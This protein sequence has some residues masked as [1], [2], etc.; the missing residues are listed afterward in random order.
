[1]VI[2]SHN[3][4]LTIPQ[5]FCQL[6]QYLACNV[7][8]KTFLSGVIGSMNR[9]RTHICVFRSPCTRVYSRTGSRIWKRA[10]FIFWHFHVRFVEFYHDSMITEYL[11]CRT[12]FSAALS[13]LIWLC[14]ER[15]EK[16]NF[17]SKPCFEPNPPCS[18]LF[19]FKYLDCKSVAITCY[20]LLY[21]AG[22]ELVKKNVPQF[23]NASRAC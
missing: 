19:A 23:Y 6:W 20:I 21:Q 12:D 14:S 4:M 15:I 3:G 7:E 8:I 22:F 5:R 11:Q 18:Q 2:T 9:Q 10:I 17:N 13:I 16:N 1:M